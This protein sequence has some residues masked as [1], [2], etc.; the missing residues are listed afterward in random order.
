MSGDGEPDKLEPRLMSWR[1]FRRWGSTETY[2]GIVVAHDRWDAIEKAVTEFGIRDLEQQKRLKAEPRSSSAK[3]KQNGGRCERFH[4]VA[5]R[6]Y[7][8]SN[9]TF[10]WPRVVR[11][12][13]CRDTHRRGRSRRSKSLR[14]QLVKFRTVTSWS[15]MTNA[16]RRSSSRARSI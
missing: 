14:Y 15:A 16:R 11:P 1:I 7:Q 4:E 2:V 8:F 13:L 5:Q 12:R 3:A 10:C 9:E 6:P